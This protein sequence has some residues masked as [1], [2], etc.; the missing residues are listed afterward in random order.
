[1]PSEADITALRSRISDLQK[2]HAQA[3]VARENALEQRDDAM[4]SLKAEFGVRT[5]EE[6]QN[7]RKKTLDE[8]NRLMAAIEESLDDLE[9]GK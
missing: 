7:L 2:K 4:L 8:Y 6:A 5:L 3:T 9:G 1:M